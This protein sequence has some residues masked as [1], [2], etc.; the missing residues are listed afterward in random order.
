MRI[1][2]DQA[3]KPVEGPGVVRPSGA[4]CNNLCSL[5][6]AIGT[7]KNNSAVLMGDGF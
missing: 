4:E 7:V 2:I 1:T 6:L 3:W 5:G